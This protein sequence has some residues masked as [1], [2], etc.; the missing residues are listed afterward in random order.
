M[1]YLILKELTL[2]DF[3]IFS[4]KHSIKFDNSNSKEN[5]ILI[6]G[7]NG[8]GKTTILEAILL[9]LYGKR[10][11][12]ITESNL[13]YSAYLR[14]TINNRS[15]N[16][17]AYISLQLSIPT[18]EQVL[19]IDI[20]RY[21]SAENSRITDTL[22]VWRN[23]HQDKYLSKNW[24]TFVEELLPVGI[25]GL[26]FFDGEKISRLAE[27]N[28]T[29]EE[30]QDS[31]KALLGIN[32][33]DRLLIDMKRLAQKKQNNIEDPKIKEEL[34][35]KQKELSETEKQIAK[36]KQERANLKTKL[37]RQE[38]LMKEKEQDF[39]RQGGTLKAN[40]ETLQERKKTL[41]E[42]LSVIKTDL[43]NAASGPLPMLL[44]QSLLDKI[45]ENTKK[46]ESAIIA[47]HV[48]NYI[49]DY[50]EKL[51]AAFENIELSTAQKKQI[52]QLMEHEENRLKTQKSSE[53]HFSLSPVSLQLIDETMSYENNKEIIGD[54]KEKI[55]KIHEYE[56]EKE[57]VENYLHVDTEDMQVEKALNKIKELNAS[58]NEIESKIEAI[59]KEIDRLDNIK[60]QLESRI[61]TLTR[62]AAE[63]EHTEEDA[64]RILKYAAITQEK[65]HEFKKKL[66]VKK[67]SE[68]SERITASFHHII[69][70]ESLLSRVEIDPNTLYLSIYDEEGEI[71]KSQLSAGEKQILSVAIL[72]GLAQSS[73]Y[74]LPVIIDTPLGRLDSSHRANFISNY[75]PY[76]SHQVIIFSTDEEL[77]D[78]YLQLLQAHIHKKYLLNYNENTKA[79]SVVEGYFQGAAS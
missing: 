75:L 56:T 41:S 3:G 45:K 73:G 59:D 25:S 22:Q 72:W 34:T 63:A 15:P 12:M 8:R 78:N 38:N 4:G 68:L 35:E 36:S 24:D 30:V 39:L 10:S 37:M 6:G 61:Q 28:Y 57:Q 31:I 46:D 1:Y 44:V 33:V 2:Y 29:S 48:S 52:K 27:D 55:A 50:N 58:I 53:L 23:S 7:L 47:G 64:K 14:K 70:K 42:E 62:N 54:L 77:H 5:I 32:V 20:K 43:I 19:D 76:A 26:F 40:R 67:V 13:S 79:T 60:T 11:P 16:N 49:E 18:S 74:K 66:T 21:W 17:N 9:A 51:S 71:I 69:G 65:M